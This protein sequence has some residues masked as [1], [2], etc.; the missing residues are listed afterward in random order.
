MLL[1]QSPLS[2][3]KSEWERCQAYDTPI[4][5]KGNR[6]G[7]VGDVEVRGHLGLS[8]HEIIEF[9]VSGETRSGSNKTS[10]PDF[11]RA[12]FGLFKELIGKDP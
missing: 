1:S 9:S 2:L 10:T 5:K 11:W 7:L 3:K 8:D 12:H 6:E 4:F